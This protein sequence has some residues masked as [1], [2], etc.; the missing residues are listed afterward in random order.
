VLHYN[1]RERA[2]EHAPAV[3]HEL[4]AEIA[5]EEQEEVKRRRDSVVE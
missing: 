4:D 1:R 3:A 5:A 2:G